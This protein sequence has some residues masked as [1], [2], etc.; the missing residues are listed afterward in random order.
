MVPFCM[1]TLKNYKIVFLSNTT[2]TGFI[3][4]SGALVQVF[5]KSFFYIFF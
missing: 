2:L 3:E 4:D 1:H 5:K